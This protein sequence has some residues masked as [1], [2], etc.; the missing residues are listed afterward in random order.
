M[1]D[2]PV[3]SV[4]TATPNARYYALHG[5]IA[6]EAAARKLTVPQAPDLL[7]RAEVALAAVSFAHAHESPW[8][9]RAHGT[10]ALA[11]KLHSGEID[12]CQHPRRKRNS[13][14]P[15]G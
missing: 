10:G 15:A 5:L 12:S 1:A 13:G 14:K 3:P 7:R 8:L 6:A 4:T 2:L 9:P 11:G